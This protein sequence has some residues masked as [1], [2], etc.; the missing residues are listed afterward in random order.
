MI[1]ARSGLPAFDADSGF[2]DARLTVFLITE[3]APSWFVGGGLMYQRILGDAGDSPI[4][5]VRGS[6]NQ[7][8]G[9]LGVVYAW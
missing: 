6:A 8:Y 1:A 9:G 5:R 2:R 3:L 7:L 4:V